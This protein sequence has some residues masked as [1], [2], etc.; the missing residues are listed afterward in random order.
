MAN[1]DPFSGLDLPDPS[2]PESVLD[3]LEPEVDEGPL[4]LPIVRPT[5]LPDL[6]FQSDMGPSNRY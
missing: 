3:G 2:D 1:G 4:G 6:G 5:F